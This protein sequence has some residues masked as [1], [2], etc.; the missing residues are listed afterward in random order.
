ML[1]CVF[2]WTV[3]WGFYV[4]VI[5]VFFKC[6]PVFQESPRVLS[7][8]LIIITS[9]LVP[10]AIQLG[11]NIFTK[12]L[13]SSQIFLS[14]EK[15]FF[16]RKGLGETVTASLGLQIAKPAHSSRIRSFACCFWVGRCVIS[17]AHQR[18]LHRDPVSC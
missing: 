12:N 14:I 9:E 16:P 4:V 10:K 7:S 15:K 6:G 3:L 13:I 17:W 18:A 5:V 1:L 2:F 8:V 11:K